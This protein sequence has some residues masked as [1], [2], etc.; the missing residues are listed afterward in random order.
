MSEDRTFIEREK[1][2]SLII[3]KLCAEDSEKA[4]E[5]AAD[6]AREALQNELS[7]AESSCAARLLCRFLL[8][9]K[10]KSRL[11][12]ILRENG[13]IRKAVFGTLNTYKHSLVFLLRRAAR[14]N[15]T[16]FTEELLALLE[17][18]PWNDEKAKD[19]SDRLNTVFV[20]KKALEAPDDYLELSEENRKLMEDFISSNGKMQ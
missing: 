14:E 13:D 1:E 20:V 17:G 15:D 19:Y 7:R 9:R 12:N 18:N 10:N 4:L 16:G 5:L 6:I 8:H 2:Y 11:V 3:E